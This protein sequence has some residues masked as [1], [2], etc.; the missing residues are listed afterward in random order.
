MEPFEVTIS[1]A[2]VLLEIDDPDRA[3][4]KGAVV[5]GGALEEGEVTVTLSGPD[6]QRT[7]RARVVTTGPYEPPVLEGLEAFH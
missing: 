1:G 4:W 3:D 7:S 6:G 5:E 2:T